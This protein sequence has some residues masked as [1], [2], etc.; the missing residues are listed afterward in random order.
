[1]SSPKP[2]NPIATANAQSGMNT[3][4]ALVQ[5]AVNMT[6]SVGPWGSTTYNPTGSISFTNSQGQTVNIPQYTQ[7][8]TYAPEQQAILDKTTKAQDNLAQLAADQS[9]KMNQYLAKPFEFDNQDAADW[10]YDLAST[11][12]LP[13]Q[14]QA[15]ADLQ[16]QL[17]NQGIRPG[18]AAYDRE[19]T[20]LTQS[21][22]DQMNQLA[23][24]GR[25]QAFGEAIQTRSQPINEL[26]AFLSGSQVAAPNSGFS[27]TPQ[28]SVGGVDYAGL[29]NSNYQAKV[30]QSNA[31]M[32]GLFGL[33]GAGVSAF[34]P[35]KPGR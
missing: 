23:L 28:A 34:A 16:S 11:R 25:S 20:R 14:K 6:N 26:T 29:V 22:T 10:S 17:T 15:A 13:Q 33:A 18:T 2:P 9:G 8:T 32:G 31:L 35:M 24:T 21:N 1:M 30:S 12:I 4:T 27:A 19:M 5:N 7:T 3:D